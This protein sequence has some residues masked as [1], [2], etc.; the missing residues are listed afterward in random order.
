MKYV[1]LFIFLTLIIVAPLVG[2][3]IEIKL[4]SLS[5]ITSSVAPLVGAWIEILFIT[6]FS[7]CKVVAPL[8]GAWIEINVSICTARKSS[9]SPCGSVD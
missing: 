8:V 4:A 7:N 9:R 3:W 1:V 6:V 5:S 2:A